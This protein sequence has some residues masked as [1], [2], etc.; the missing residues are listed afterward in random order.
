MSTSSSFAHTQTSITFHESTTIFDD[1]KPF[2]DNYV[3]KNPFYQFTA[4]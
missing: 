3:V 2:L 1:C 4:Q